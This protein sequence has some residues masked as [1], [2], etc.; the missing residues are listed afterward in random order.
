[1]INISKRFMVASAAALIS[2][3]GAVGSAESAESRGGVDNPRHNYVVGANAR[4]VNRSRRFSS[5]RGHHVRRHHFQRYYGYNNNYYSNDDYRYYSYNNHRRY[6]TYGPS[7]G[8]NIPGLSIYLGGNNDCQ[9]FHRRWNA[10]GSRY[11]RSRY[12][13]CANG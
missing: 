12:Y 4:H 7:I 9:V 5:N 2:L 13:S 6:R 8:L 1:M 11:W 10:T 3:M